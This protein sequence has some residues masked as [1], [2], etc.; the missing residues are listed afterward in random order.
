MCMLVHAYKI[1]GRIHTYNWHQ[2][3]APVNSFIPLE[4]LKPGACVTYL[5]NSKISISPLMLEE[6]R[7]RGRKT[8]K[9]DEVGAKRGALLQ[10][11]EVKQL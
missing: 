3:V 11:Q 4:F 1:S 10:P 8:L 5:N 6:G 9:P 7:A 2:V